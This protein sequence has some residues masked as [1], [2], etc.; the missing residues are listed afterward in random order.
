MGLGLVLTSIE[1]NST[2]RESIYT[3]ITQHQALRFYSTVEILKKGWTS[4]NQNVMGLYHATKQ[5]S[6]GGLL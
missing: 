6:I 5:P 1:I 4:L 2:A 3:P